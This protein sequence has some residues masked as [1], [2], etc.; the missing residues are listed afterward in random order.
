MI[1]MGTFSIAGTIFVTGVAGPGGIMTPA[2]TCPVGERCIFWQDTGQ[3][4]QNMK[5]DISPLGL[6]NGD[7][8]DPTF[9]G[10]DNGNIFTLMDPPETPGG[11]F[12]P[13]AFMSFVPQTL[14]TTVLNINQFPLGIN[15]PG[16]CG[17]P[18]APGQVCTPPG[19]GFN[20]E[21][22]TASSSSVT[23]RFLGTTNDSASTWTG[24]FSSQFNTMPFQSVLNTLNTQG[25]V[26][27]T[28]AGQITL[29]PIPEPETLALLL[30]GGTLIALSRLRL[31][32]Q[33]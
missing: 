13:T 27:N 8:T 25:F 22:L 14:V 31:R 21:N 6:P 26:S 29:T 7:I 33:D 3:P 9:P 23:W 5:V 30:L 28:F 32:K 2:G 17:L 20:L 1:T 11:P 12:A 19:S 15:G 4:A 24:T 10:N 16:Q 18:P